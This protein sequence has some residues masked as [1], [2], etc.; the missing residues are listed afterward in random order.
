MSWIRKRRDTTDHV[1]VTERLSA[2]LDGELSPQE[3]RAVSQ[4]LAT[5]QTCRWQFDSLQQTVQWT[6]EL[7]TIPVPRVFTI[8][9]PAQPV[10]AA[11]Q[12]RGWMPLLQ[13]ATA[14]IALLLVIV[15]AGDVMLT[16]VLGPGNVPAS[17]APALAPQ[18][19]PVM[20][21]SVAD[22]VPT[23]ET[24]KVEKEIVLGSESAAE[25]R[26][27]E[28]DGVPVPQ[29]VSPTQD[30]GGEPEA[31]LMM[32]ADIAPTQPPEAGI[33]TAMGGGSADAQEKSSER[34]A[35]P[36]P[37]MVEESAGEAESAA[38]MAGPTAT[39]APANTPTAVSTVP[40]LPTVVPTI[41]VEARKLLPT[42]ESDP[43][44]QTVALLRQPYVTWLRGAECVLGVLL[45]TLATITVA[46]VLQRRRSR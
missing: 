37:S 12:R 38:D 5:C 24:E 33:M 18:S 26:V 15:V 27:A 7:P 16:G 31:P 35:A 1:Y 2:Y 34:A 20:E 46:T 28:A 17:S 29:A 23:Q 39:R 25:E 8:P 36:Q 22:V 30:P 43:G 10:P 11:R 3:Q 40:A 14:L 44:L 4:H 19:E 13:G 32:E 41:V 21:L 9:A 45:V 6:R 42:V